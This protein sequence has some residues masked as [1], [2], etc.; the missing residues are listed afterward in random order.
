MTR[1]TREE[2]IVRRFSVPSVELAPRPLRKG[3]FAIGV[4]FFIGGATLGG[5]TGVA[6]SSILIWLA[7]LTY[8]LEVLIPRRL[9]VRDFLPAEG[10][11][12]AAHK[13][14]CAAGSVPL[15]DHG[16]TEVL[17]GCRTMADAAY[18]RLI[19]ELDPSAKNTALRPLNN[20]QIARRFELLAET[21]DISEVFS[22]ELAAARSLAESFG[23]HLSTPAGPH[24]LAAF[25]DDLV[26]RLRRLHTSSRWG[27][28]LPGGD[29]YRAFHNGNLSAEQF[30]VLGSVCIFSRKN[31]LRFTRNASYFGDGS[32][33]VLLIRASE[34]EDWR[35]HCHL[36]Q[37]S[38]E[39]IWDL[40]QFTC[41]WEPVQ[42]LISRSEDGMRLLDVLLRRALVQ[43]SHILVRS[44]PQLEGTNVPWES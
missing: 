41:V 22:D 36:S 39:A 37:L 44:C 11:V 32:N 24:L 7:W 14:L 29:C 33:E 31:E 43:R 8:R 27:F 21:K 18:S 26:G 15:S 9:S 13:R 6:I 42:R 1:E 28:G 10:A 19:V 34:A 30:W 16:A 12:L 35:L 17:E 25:V 4:L 5:A 20:R 38:K 23:Q 2:R 40:F 3:L